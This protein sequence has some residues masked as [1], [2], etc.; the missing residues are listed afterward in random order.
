MERVTV[1]SMLQETLH[2]T[3]HTGD[4]DPPL[5]T[6]RSSDS[7]YQGPVGLLEFV[8]HNK[9]RY[10]SLLNCTGEKPQMVLDIMQKALDLPDVREETRRAIP[11]AMM[12][13]CRES[14]VFNAT[15]S[16]LHGGTPRCLR[17]QS[18]ADDLIRNFTR[19]GILW[20]YLHHPNVLPFYGIFKLERK[21]GYVCVI[22]PW[23]SKGNLNDYYNAA[24][25]DVA[26][27]SLIMDT[28]EDLR[29]L[30]SKRITHGDLKPANILI[31]LSGT[32]VLADF[33][34]SS[35]LD[36]EIPRWTSVATMDGIILS[37]P[38]FASD[39]YSVASVTYKVLAGKIPY[40][41]LSRGATVIAQVLRGK[42]P[43]RP[44]Q[45]LESEL[46]PEIWVIMEGCWSRIHNQ[47]PTVEAVI[48][49]LSEIRHSDLTQKRLAAQALDNCKPQDHYQELPPETF[50]LAV[51][52][53]D[54]GFC[55]AEINL[56][57]ELNGFSG[58]EALTTSLKTTQQAE[59]L[60]ALNVSH[61]HS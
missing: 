58:L 28:L 4:S 60:G 12:R 45:H 56:L 16:K 10:K 9:A 47:R 54:I 51:R 50:R 37:Q 55:H 39:I 3:G 1:N 49:A 6:Y 11:H 15:G 26:R 43:K 30:H 35:V 33:G 48:K 8:L 61:L 21:L 25:P 13:L 5:E 59:L 24:N 40:H 53:C 38:T 57:L 36:A 34:L 29:Y 41:E 27:F 7:V 23:M 19:E 46:T 20:N 31:S 18:Q 17:Q 2:F 14:G 22:S 52:G 32:A 42:N 44:P